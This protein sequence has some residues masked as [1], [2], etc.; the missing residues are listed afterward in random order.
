[1][2]REAV[3]EETQ[4]P[5]AV[6]KGMRLTLNVGALVAFAIAAQQSGRWLERQDVV[7]RRVTDL[8]RLRIDDNLKREADRKEDREQ[9]ES[10]RSGLKVVSIGLEQLLNSYKKGPTR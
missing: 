7:E 3:T 4:S 2:A 8:E 6:G 9:F 1:M 5:L 10:L